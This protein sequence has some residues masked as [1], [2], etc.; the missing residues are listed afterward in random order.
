MMKI[1]I[2]YIIAWLLLLVYI[3]SITSCINDTYENNSKKIQVEIQPAIATLEGMA[4]G[5]SIAG[6]LWTCD[7]P[8][9]YIENPDSLITEVRLFKKGYYTFTLWVSNIW[10]G[11]DSANQHITVK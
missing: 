6:T 4:K 3:L 1:L 8:D 2:F 11:L 9:V 5:D 7:S 10:G